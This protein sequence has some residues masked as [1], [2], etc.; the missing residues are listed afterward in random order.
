VWRIGPTQDIDNRF[1]G[2]RESRLAEAEVQEMR[3]PPYPDIL[4]I[5]LKTICRVSCLGDKRLAIIGLHLKAACSK[6][7]FDIRT[8]VFDNQTERERS[9]GLA[10]K[11]PANP[12]YPS[13]K[14]QEVIRHW[15]KR[16]QE[17]LHKISDPVDE[18]KPNSGTVFDLVP[19]ISSQHAVEVVLDLT[20]VMGFEIPDTVI[21]RGGYHSCDEMVEHLDTRLEVLHSER[22]SI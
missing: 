17:D 15:W 6:K 14:V 10:L 16:E 7:M 2:P 4:H 19:V 22:Q 8:V 11:K 21:K 12:P 9:M 1:E 20:E 18:L 3:R 5:L 13:G